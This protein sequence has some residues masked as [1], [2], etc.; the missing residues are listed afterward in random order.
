MDGSREDPSD[1]ALMPVEEIE[2]KDISAL[3]VIA[4]EADKVILESGNL[5]EVEAA[6]VFDAGRVWT[7]PSPAVHT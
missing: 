2:L 4:G 3:R 7:E 6:D 5:V 1:N